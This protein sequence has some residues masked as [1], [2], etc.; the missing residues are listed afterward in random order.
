MDHHLRDDAEIAVCM[1]KTYVHQESVTNSNVCF[2]DTN[3]LHHTI[4]T[5][6]VQVLRG[7]WHSVHTH[8]HTWHSVQTHKHTWHSVHTHTHTHL[9]HCFKIVQLVQHKIYIQNG[10]QSRPTAENDSD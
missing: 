9:L 8:T 4:P 1:D 6:A 10:L 5:S 3:W 2:S 7:T